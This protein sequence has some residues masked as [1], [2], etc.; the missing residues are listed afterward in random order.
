MAVVGTAEVTVTALTAGFKRSMQQAFR[1]T[2]P[3][4]ATEGQRHGRQFG[5]RFRV[6]FRAIYQETFRSLREF[7]TQEGGRQGKLFGTE[8]GIAMRREMNLA[9]AASMDDLLKQMRANAGRAAKEF[10]DE[11]NDSLDLNLDDVSD[12][13]VDVDVDGDADIDSILPSDA[14]ADRGGGNLGRRIG[15]AFSDQFLAQAR[16]ANAAFTKMYA[17]GTLLG[18][19]LFLVV[20]GLS[21]LVSALVTLAAVAT[22]AAGSL[23]VLPSLIG[24][25]GQAG[26]TAAFAMAGVSKAIGAGFQQAASGAAGGSR[27]A[28]LAARRVADAEDDLA[29]AQRDA[30]VAQLALNGARKEAIEDLQ[31]LGFDVE[32]AA[33]A[34]ERAVLTLQNATRELAETRANPAAT[35]QELQETS[36]SYREAELAVRRARDRLEDLEQ[37]QDDAAEAGVEGSRAVLEAQED[38]A[39]AN[40]RVL[41]AEKDLA[42][43]REDQAA[44][45]ADGA[46]GASAYQQAL[47]ELSPEARKFVEYIV[48]LKGR[49][50]ELQAAAGRKLFPQLTESIEQLVDNFFPALCRALLITGDALGQFSK[51][52][53]DVISSAGF[54]DRF[55]TI[56]E[57]NTT[58]ITRA[59]EA[60]ADVINAVSGVLVAAGPLVD[61]FTEWIVKQTDAFEEYATSGRGIEGM[62]AFFGRAGDAAADLGAI[63][64]DVGRGLKGV[65]DAALSPGYRLIDVIGGVAKKF[66]DLNTDVVR[67]NALQNFF[68]DANE[69]AVQVMGLLTD[70]LKVFVKMGAAPGVGKAAAILREDMV[71]SL[72]KLVESVEGAGPSFARLVSQVTELLASLADSNAVQ[73]FLDVLTGLVWIVNSLLDIPFVG[74]ILGVIGPI[75]AATK[76]FQIFGNTVSFFNQVVVGGLSTAAG[77]VRQFGA[78]LTGELIPGTTVYV[79]TLRQGFID[80]AAGVG[81]EYDR[82]R[83]R[84]I[85]A[86]KT[87]TGPV[88]A[89]RQFGYGLRALTT[90]VGGPWVAAAGVGA[91]AVGIWYKRVLDARKA[92]AEFN[93][94]V[95]ELTG[96]ITMETVKEFIKQDLSKFS[97]G[98]LQ[99]KISMGEFVGAISMGDAGVQSLTERMNAL[100]VAENA[101]KLVLDTLADKQE[102]WTKKTGKLRDEWDKT[103]PV[104]DQTS[105]YIKNYRE[106]AGFAIASIDEWTDVEN[107]HKT[108]MDMLSGSLE[109]ARS[110]FTLLNRAALDLEE[111]TIRQ[112]DAEQSLTSDLEEQIKTIRENADITKVQRAEAEAGAKALDI[113][114]ESGRRAR[115]EIIDRM[116]AINDIAQAQIDH[117]VAT[118]E[119][120]R[121]Y[122]Q[123]KTDLLNSAEAAGFT[124]DKVEEL[125]TSLEEAEGERTIRFT[126]IMEEE[127]LV[128]MMEP[129]DSMTI[130]KLI[131]MKPNFDE[132][133]LAEVARA[134]ADLG[135]MDA[136]VVYTPEINKHIFEVAKRDLRNIL[137]DEKTHKARRPEYVPDFV[138]AKY[139]A[140]QAKLDDLLKGPDGKPRD[141]QYFVGA[142]KDAYEQLMNDL[143]A[144][145]VDPATN[146]P[147]AVEFMSEADKDS[148]SD[149]MLRLGYVKFDENGNLRDVPF[150]SALDPKSFNEVKEKLRQEEL[151]DRHVWFTSHVKEALAAGTMTLVFD[152][153]KGLYYAPQPKAAGGP[154][155]GP[156]GP[157]D[158]RAGLFALSHGEFVLSAKAVKA[159]GGMR[160]TIALH[161]L[162]RSGYRLPGMQSGGTVQ[163][164]PGGT[165]ARLGEGGRAERITPLDSSGLSA[166]D[167]AIIEELRRLQV[168][169]AKRGDGGFSLSI[170]QLVS[171]SP[172]AVPREI[173]AEMRSE[174][175]RMG[176][177]R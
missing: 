136:T 91:I 174:S 36:L 124:R 72:E 140:L 84:A 112:L 18:A 64:A 61:R 120:N 155:Y 139:D 110:N 150:Y 3:I 81:A 31:Q 57:D 47:A 51:S 89:T 24:A 43:A 11:F 46:S 82:L 10:S 107:S 156:G 128:K 77:A 170:G 69:N 145:L 146:Q 17:A 116:K 161:N 168:M 126:M 149:T 50:D 8:F 122:E 1:D 148:L 142:D 86:G 102:A 157:T 131:R 20:G 63:A 129:L 97:D 53:S 135:I 33:L 114:T 35:V 74:Y 56:T 172:E 133:G 92:T 164:S 101:Q 103:H 95:D 40:D 173:M 144:A 160:S 39:D 123:N 15:S 67:K 28:V 42:R 25:I 113:N 176:Q 78:L 79:S 68:F 109:K 115:E 117:K 162:L 93:R 48:S 22:E 55:R 159:L 71:P 7:T 165:L 134:M 52:I 2:R 58:T 9:F 34:E 104:L 100:G 177:Y 73:T 171:P 127:A 41:E 106:E 44:A 153:S 59:G 66:G 94:T 14:D 80:M 169:Q 130:E 152:P 38:I 105:V 12:V 70:I 119:V 111:A 54:I 19:G 151:K 45:M 118:D 132:L 37:A 29:E 75:V 98:L 60:I 30:L 154:I 32:E 85:D 99:G 26:I 158:D 23:V 147:Y 16:R 141:P 27:S 87:M 76:A 125:I 166:G 138:K 62:A 137:F 49:F 13:D 5:Q 108:M 6:Q 175:Y 4:A 163:P 83:T 21:S 96:S 121:I 90:L 88:G 143:T 65:F 167:R